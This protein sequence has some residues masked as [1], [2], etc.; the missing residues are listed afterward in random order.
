ML[1][2]STFCPHKKTLKKCK[3]YSYCVRGSQNLATSIIYGTLVSNAK[4]NKHVKFLEELFQK[5][6]CQSL[7][8]FSIKPFEQKGW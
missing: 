7:L 3:T 6:I 5:V 2:F 4:T 8:S 1:S